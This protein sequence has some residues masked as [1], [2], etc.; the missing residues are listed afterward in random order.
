[1]VFQARFAGSKGGEW[2]IAR[3]SNPEST[4]AGVG[5]FQCLF[6]NALVDFAFASDSGGFPFVSHDPLIWVH[7]ACR[8]VWRVWQW[9]ELIDYKAD[10]R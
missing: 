4:S 10:S 5:V 9:H 8:F 1:M 6:V 7:V 2:K 3:L